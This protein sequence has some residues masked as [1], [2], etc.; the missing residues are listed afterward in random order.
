MPIPNLTAKKAEDFT[1]TLHLRSESSSTLQRVSFP[2]DSP[3]FEMTQTRRASIQIP[4]QKIRLMSPPQRP[5][6]TVAVA[7][8]TSREQQAAPRP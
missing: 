4:L 3:F 6:I 8:T 2:Q 5:N 1:I 7:T